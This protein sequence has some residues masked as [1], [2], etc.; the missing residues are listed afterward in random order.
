M[1]RGQLHKQAGRQTDMAG[2]MLSLPTVMCSYATQAEKALVCLHAWLHD[3]RRDMLRKEMG[4]EKRGGWNN[5]VRREKEMKSITEAGLQ[6]KTW[7][8]GRQKEA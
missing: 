2:L 8:D 1:L 5:R 3:T 6:E 4:D 7:V